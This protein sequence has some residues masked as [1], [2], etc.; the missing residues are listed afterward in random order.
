MLEFIQTVLEKELTEDEKLKFLVEVADK[1]VEAEE[2]ADIVRY[3]KSKQAIKLDLPDSLDIVWTGWS[4]LPRINTS[5]LTCL[6]LAKEGIKITKHWNN[7]ASGRFGSFDLIEELGYKIPTTREEVLEEY[8]KNN[9]AFLHAKKFYPFFKEFGEVRKRYWKPTIFNILGPLLAPVNSENQLIGCSFVGKM[10][11]MIKAT[12]LLWRKR[13]MVVRWDDWLDEVTLSDETK[14]YE[15]SDGKI[16]DYKVSPEEFGFKRVL[17]EE[18]MAEEIEDKI[19][20]A[21]AII[22]WTSRDAHN[23]LVELNMKMARRLFS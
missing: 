12:K 4:W 15:L 2:L 16:K 23:D 6:K 17:I 5:T 1:K 3:I 10:E 18:I 14:V 21:K 22:A 7:A 20:I 13:I 9:L 8:E 19:A 11:L